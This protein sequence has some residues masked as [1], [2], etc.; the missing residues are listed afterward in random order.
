MLEGHFHF[1]KQESILGNYWRSFYNFQQPIN[2]FYNIYL[3]ALQN[4]L[5]HMARSRKLIVKSIINTSHYIAE[6][7]EYENFMQ[8]LAL[9]FMVT[10]RIFGRMK[11]II[12]KPAKLGTRKKMISNVAEYKTFQNVTAFE[13]GLAL[14]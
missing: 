11:H 12:S 10:R 4:S 13:L 1:D 5:N 3:T 8:L 2:G 9:C 6:C 14:P 7:P